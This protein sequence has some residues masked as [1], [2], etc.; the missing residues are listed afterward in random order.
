M[1]RKGRMQL[2]ADPNEQSGYVISGKYRTTVSGEE[3]ILAASDSYCLAAGVSQVEEGIQ[4]G[5]VFSLRG[6]Y[7]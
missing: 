7:L 6:E 2:H 3:E 1:G 4:A 5:E